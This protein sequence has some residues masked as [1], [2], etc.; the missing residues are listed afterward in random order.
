M[1]SSAVVVSKK[2][3]IDHVCP[4]DSVE[5]LQHDEKEAH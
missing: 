1:F 5:S 3:Y 4:V 2:K